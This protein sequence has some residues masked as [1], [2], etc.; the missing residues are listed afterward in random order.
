MVE[1]EMKDFWKERWLTDEEVKRV[2]LLDD[3]FI[4]LKYKKVEL[5]T[6][7]DVLGCVAIG[8]LDVAKDGETWMVR[9]TEFGGDKAIALEAVWSVNIVVGAGRIVIEMRR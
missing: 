7:T 1:R 5:H 9:A 8:E 2:E 6:W 3:L 4:E